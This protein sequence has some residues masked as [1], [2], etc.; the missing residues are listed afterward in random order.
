MLMAT[1]CSLDFKE[2]HDL[3]L[4][5]REKKIEGFFF[6]LIP[7]GNFHMI[8]TKPWESLASG[9]SE[10][11]LHSPEAAW[12]G[13]SAP[14]T[15]EDTQLKNKATKEN[16]ELGRTHK[17]ILKSHPWSCTGYPKNPTLCW[18]PC[19][20]TPWALAAL[21]QGPHWPQSC[22]TRPLDCMAGRGNLQLWEILPYKHLLCNVFLTYFQP[23]FLQIFQEEKKFQNYKKNI[24]VMLNK[25]YQMKCPVSTT[26]PSLFITTFILV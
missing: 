4:W 21:G 24:L 1:L 12:M 6:L 3:S 14:V 22:G 16:P 9:L 8:Q 15:M 5:G 20:N 13:T 2:E 18:E 11:H 7:D 23:V 10:T 26:A 19:P 25:S 17:K